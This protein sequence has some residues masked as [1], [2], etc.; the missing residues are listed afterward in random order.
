MKFYNLGDKTFETVQ[1]GN[2]ISNRMQNARIKLLLALD[3]RWL[4][5]SNNV[6]F[7][8]LSLKT[9]PRNSMNVTGFISNDMSTSFML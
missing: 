9:C 5:V 6:E 7:H 2:S 3:E 4:C 1:I 8:D